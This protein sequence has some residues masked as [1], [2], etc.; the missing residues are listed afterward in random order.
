M[1]KALK[2]AAKGVF[3]T[4]SNPRV[5]CVIVKNGQVISK[6]FHQ[7]VGEQHAEALALAKAGSQ[8]EGSTVYVTLEPCSHHGKNPPCADALIAAGVKTVVVC[9]DDP[10][11]LVAGKGYIKL[12]NAGIEVITGVCFKKGLKLNKGFLKRMQTGL[13]WVSGKLAQS[14][15]GRTAMANGESFWITGKKSRQDVQY[16]RGR[17]QA[18]VT[19]I[20]TVLLDDCR[21]NVRPNELPKR[22][23]K[24]THD[25]KN[26]Q[27]LRVVIDSQMRI[28][29]DAKI[30]QDPE[31]ALVVTA[32]Y[33]RFKGQQLLDVGVKVEF[34]PAKNGKVDLHRVIKHLGELQINEVLIETGATLAGAFLQEKLLD[35]LLVYTAPV[36]MGS[37]GR[38]TFKID[39]EEMSERLHIKPISIKHIGNDWRLRALV[40]K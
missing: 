17:S 39:I 19:G 14:L 7:R 18:I 12:E 31:N 36:I 4:G 1:K 27:P 30:L 25:F 9:N 37:L 28:P 8:A 3:T 29:L 38:P 26:K 34:F 5:G 10:N 6:A 40:E 32:V 21:L 15:D 33:D 20:E 16:W 35:E 13:P 24:L 2:Q 22:F 23:R 11:P